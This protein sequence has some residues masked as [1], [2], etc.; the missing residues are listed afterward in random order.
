MAIPPVIFAMNSWLN[1][2]VY[3]VNIDVGM[4]STGILITLFIAW[5]TIVNQAIRS[6]VSKPIE[7]LKEE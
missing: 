5:L 1:N 2:F 6:A 4:V 7:S 3:K